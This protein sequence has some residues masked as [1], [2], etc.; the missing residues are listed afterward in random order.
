MEIRGETKQVNLWESDVF[1]GFFTVPFDDIWNYNFIGANFEE[2]EE[3]I[4]KVD[5]PKQY[6]DPLHRQAHFF[7][8]QK[9]YLNPEDGQ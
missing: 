3:D 9:S 1:M 7:S 4:A 5:K 2:G 6:Y 8:F